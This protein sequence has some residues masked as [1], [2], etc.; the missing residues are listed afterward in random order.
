[1][2]TNAYH[3]IMTTEPRQERDSQADILRVLA[4]NNGRMH[5]T[6]ARVYLHMTA[7][8][9]ADAVAAL[10]SDGLIKRLPGPGFGYL[11]TPEYEAPILREGM[12]VGDV[13]E[14]AGVTPNTV[15]RWLRE[16]RLKGFKPS[17]GKMGSY[18]IPESEV[19]RLLGELNPVQ[20][21]QSV[22]AG[23]HRQPSDDAL[24]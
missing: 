20:A 11:A 17:G 1:M 16:G 5:W 13:A 23:E 6:A 19:A 12:L 24:E 9:F 21:E 10:L 14:I 8:H 7:D 2:R 18:R 3:G 15:Q 4:K 22:Y